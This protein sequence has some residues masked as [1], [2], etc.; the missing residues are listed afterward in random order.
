MVEA[1]VKKL[2][3]HIVLDIESQLLATSRDHGYYIR[4]IYPQWYLFHRGKFLVSGRRM[5][6]IIE[7]ANHHHN[8]DRGAVL[9]WAPP[10]TAGRGTT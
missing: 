9:L 7:N 10:K 6:D 2:R 8:Y 4:W 5:P 1:V 3:W